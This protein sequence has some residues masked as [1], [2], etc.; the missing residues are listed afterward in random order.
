MELFIYEAKTPWNNHTEI[1]VLCDTYGEN[2]SS[3]FGS[4]VTV[5]YEKAYP[6]VVQK[7]MMKFYSIMA[8]NPD[9]KVHGANMG[10]TWVLSVPDGPDVG[11]MSLAIRE[12]TDLKTGYQIPGVWWNT[13]SMNTRFE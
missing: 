9:N 10:P 5:R 7:V 3:M 2:I 8:N 6:L 11:P 4:L 1:R 13:V 12:P